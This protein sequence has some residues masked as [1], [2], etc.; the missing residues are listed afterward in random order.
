MPLF[1]SIDVV[2]DAGAGGQ[3][4]PDLQSLTGQQSSSD[5]TARVQTST[6]QPRINGPEESPP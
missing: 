6:Q 3:F 1:T 4:S 5:R 2:P